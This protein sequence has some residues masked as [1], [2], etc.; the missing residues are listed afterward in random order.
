MFTIK[1]IIYADAGHLL[2]GSRV[3]AFQ[4]FASFCEVEEEELYV[5]DMHV[6]NG[7]IVFNNNTIR[8][9]FQHT[10]YGAIKKQII[11]LRY[12]NDDQIAIM[13]NK[14]DSEEDLLAYNK[15]QEWREWAGVMARK[16]IIVLT[17]NNE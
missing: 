9:S 17:T 14:E 3:I 15:M 1:D 4:S 11:G 6:E 16:I 12:N 2:R 10:E 7:R 13:L 8:W 5:D